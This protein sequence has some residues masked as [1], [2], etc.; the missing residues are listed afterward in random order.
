MHQ[1]SHA[2]GAGAILDAARG[3]TARERGAALPVILILMTALLVLGAL[4][5]RLT[6]SDTR[7]THATVSGRRATYCAEGGLVAGRTFI[8]ANMVSW[9]LMLDQDA[10]ND[11]DGYPVTG[12]L[13]GDGTDDWQVTIKDND[14]ELGTNNPYVDSDGVVFMVGTCL[15]EPDTPREVMQLISVGG[16]GTNYRAQAGAGGGNTGNTN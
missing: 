9:S 7:G 6:I 16:G 15:A 11:P 2:P 12:D 5:L 3:R 1:P 4:A 13:D 8:A 10:A 14:D